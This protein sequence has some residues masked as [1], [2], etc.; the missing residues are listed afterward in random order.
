[1]LIRHTAVPSVRKPVQPDGIRAASFASI[2]SIKS[3]LSNSS[4]LKI[5]IKHLEELT[6]HAEKVLQLLKLPYRVMSMCT[7]DLGFHCSEEI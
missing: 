3:S 1:M 6:G 7:G 4:N 2:N 5:L